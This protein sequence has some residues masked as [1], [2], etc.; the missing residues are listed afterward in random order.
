MPRSDQ[1]AVP[2]F[3]LRLIRVPILAEVTDFQRP[4]VFRIL[5]R[6]VALTVTM[7]LLYVVCFSFSARSIGEISHVPVP[8]SPPRDRF[9]NLFF[10]SPFVVSCSDIVLTV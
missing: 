8:A 7:S 9:F 10:F 3:P 4:F 2:A 1:D 5:P 6:D